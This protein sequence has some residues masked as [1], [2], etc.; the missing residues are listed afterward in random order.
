MCCELIEIRLGSIFCVQA[1]YKCRVHVVYISCTYRV[2]VVYRSCTC[3]VHVVYMSC[4]C[5]VHIMLNCKSRV[6]VVFFFFSDR[7]T[8][9]QTER[10]QGRNID[11]Q[12][13]RKTERHCGMFILK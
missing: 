4:S 10:K 8:D 2:H 11:S 6:R 7:R 13:D 12:A 1:A 5:R 3:R 9:R